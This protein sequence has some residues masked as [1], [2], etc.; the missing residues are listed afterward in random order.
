MCFS[1]HVESKSLTLLVDLDA[2]V[3]ADVAEHEH[4]PEHGGLEAEP[5]E[6]LVVHNGFVNKV[7][8]GVR[9]VRGLAGA[10][11]SGASHAITAQKIETGNRGVYV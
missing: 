8:V 6:E 10:Q 7:P 1:K 11:K 5:R 9:V 3:V 2:T 4:L